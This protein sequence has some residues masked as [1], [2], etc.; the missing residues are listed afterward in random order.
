MRKNLWGINMNILLDHLIQ[1]SRE[2]YQFG[3][4]PEMFCNC[5]CQLGVLTYKSFSER[6]IS[7][8]NLLVDAHRL[9]LNDDM[10]DKLIILRMDKRFMERVRSKKVFSSIIIGNI[11]SDQSAKV[12]FVIIVFVF[13]TFI[14][15]CYCYFMF[16]SELDNTTK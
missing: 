16:A 11:E 2:E 12:K 1:E 13:V 15:T 5:T 3:C 14:V 8:A 4:L 6:M 9:H 10:I 7:A